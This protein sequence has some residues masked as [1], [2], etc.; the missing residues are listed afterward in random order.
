MLANAMLTRRTLLGSSLAALAAA[1]P[2]APIIDTHIHLFAP[3]RRRFPLHP[4]AAYV[5]E[6]SPLDAYLGFVKAAGV[7]RVVIVH[8]EPYQDDHR[9]LEHCFANEPSP[10][11][12][13]GT[14][15]FDPIDPATPERMRQLMERNPNRIV[16]L[17]IHCTRERGAPPT[18]SG[19][20]RDRDLADPRAGRPCAR[21]APS[22]WR[23]SST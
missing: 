10:L 22:A 13:K 18:S 6:D 16:A 1:A 11:F 5:P 21:L 4:N 8:P 23:S 12:F 7:S 17:R 14:C 3:D 20:I 2:D 9:Y 15:L 19:S